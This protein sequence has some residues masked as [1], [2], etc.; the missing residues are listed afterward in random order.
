[1]ENNAFGMQILQQSSNIEVHFNNI[2][3]NEIGI[4][5]NGSKEN[6]KKITTILLRTTEKVLLL[7]TIALWMPATI[8]GGLYLVR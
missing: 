3:N 8:T 6:I 5:V 2:M 7:Q 1:M 4:Y